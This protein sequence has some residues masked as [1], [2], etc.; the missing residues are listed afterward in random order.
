MSL[1]LNLFINNAC[2][3]LPYLSSPLVSLGNFSFILTSSWSFGG[4]FHLASSDWPSDCP[5]RCDGSFSPG[6]AAGQ[7]DERRDP[8]PYMWRAYSLQPHISTGGWLLNR[9]IESSLGVI[10]SLSSFPVCTD[11]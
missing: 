8:P 3:R 10:K 11:L 9:T 5:S 1:F 2:R 6:A 4:F 7:F